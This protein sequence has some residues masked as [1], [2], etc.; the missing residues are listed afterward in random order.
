MYEAK[1]KKVNLLKTFEYDYQTHR[2]RA[3]FTDSGALNILLSSD[4]M[5]KLIRNERR[6]ELADGSD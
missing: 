4:D 3:G 5:R 1:L 6:C 2:E